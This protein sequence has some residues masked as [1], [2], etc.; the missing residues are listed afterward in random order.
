MI[1]QIQLKRSA[2]RSRRYC[3]S[4][5]NKATMFICKY[6]TGLPLLTLIS[7]VPVLNFFAFKQTQRMWL[8]N[9]GFH[10]AR[11]STSDPASTFSSRICVN[12]TY[13]FFLASI[14]IELALG[15]VHPIYYFISSTGGIHG[16]VVVH[17]TAGQHVEQ[18]ILHQ[19]H[20]S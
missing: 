13:K 2:R 14:E 19:G 16:T 12:C 7:L 15:R 11:G 17:W 20:D 8:S 9:C 18:L 5:S 6:K 10:I 1:N 4:G 3:S